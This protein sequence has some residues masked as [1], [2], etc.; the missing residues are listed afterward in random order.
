MT[1]KQ[2]PASKPPKSWRGKPGYEHW[3]ELKPVVYTQGLGSK[4]GGALY[5][6]LTIW[7]R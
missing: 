3:G 7:R 1:E 2:K 6:L 4:I 5:S